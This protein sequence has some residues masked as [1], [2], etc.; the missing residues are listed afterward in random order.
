M[1]EMGGLARLRGGSLTDFSI[2]FPP[3]SLH[4]AQLLRSTG[5]QNTPF[6]DFTSPLRVSS[7]R[8]QIISGSHCSWYRQFLLHVGLLYKGFRPVFPS[9]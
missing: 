4:Q 8:V 3:L 2:T 9:S 7:L 5:Y 6:V 1:Y